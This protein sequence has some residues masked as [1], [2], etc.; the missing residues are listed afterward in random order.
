MS[1]SKKIINWNQ[2]YRDNQLPWE[3]GQVDIHLPKVIKKHEIEK[4]KALEIGCG[5]GINAMWLAQQGFTLSA[6][7][8]SPHAISQAKMKHAATESRCQFFVSDFLHDEIPNPPYQFVYDRG[9]F[10]IFDTTENRIHFAAKVAKILA[11]KGI[12]HSLIGSKD[13]PPRETGPPRLSACDIIT[14]VEPYFEILE[15]SSTTFDRENHIHVCAWIF[16][17]RRR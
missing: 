14:A 11:P 2:H 1:S 7:D 9:V 5:T 3:N 10:H 12:W 8:I 6:L 15:L 4:G 16:V 13:G 17:G